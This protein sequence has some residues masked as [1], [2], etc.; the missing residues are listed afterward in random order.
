MGVNT[1][2]LLT[3]YRLRR[4]MHQ[5]GDAARMFHD[6]IEIIFRKLQGKSKNLHHATT[7]LKDFLEVGKV[8]FLEAWQMLFLRPLVASI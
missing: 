4:I 8:G 6:T 5:P 7:K 1:R 3:R 2:D